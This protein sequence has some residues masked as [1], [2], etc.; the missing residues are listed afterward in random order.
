MYTGNGKDWITI[1]SNKQ[2]HIL[3][4]DLVDETKLFHWD[5]LVHLVDPCEVFFPGLTRALTCLTSTCDQ[6]PGAAPISITT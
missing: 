5:G 4:Q 1:Q 2:F 6:A 3:N